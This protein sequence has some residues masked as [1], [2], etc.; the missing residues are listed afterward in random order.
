M[1]PLESDKV[2]LERKYRIFKQM[3]CAC[4][5]VRSF[6]ISAAGKAK[7]LRRFFML[8]VSLLA[9]AKWYPILFDTPMNAVRSVF[10]WLTLA[11]VLAFVVCAFALKDEKRAKF[12]KC[13]LIFAICYAGALGATF[14]TFTFLEDGIVAVLFAP[15]LVLIATIAGSALAL[16]LKRNRL[17]Y[18]LAGGATG[19]AFLAVLVCMAVYYASG[20]AEDFNGATVTVGENVALYL[21]SIGLI[22]VL[23]FLAFFFGRREKKGFDSKTISYAAIC[24]A[25]SFALSY[26]RIVK[27]PQGGSVT[28][29]SLLPLMIYAYMFGVKKGVFAGFIYG[30]LQALQ[31]PYIIHPAQF[32]LD[33]PIAFSCVGL[34]GIFAHLKSLEKLPQIQFALGALTGSGFRLF[35][36]LVSGVFAFSEYSTLDN[37]W[38]YSLVYNS[39]FVFPDI[40]IVIAA[41]VLVFSSKSFVKQ[42]RKFQ[43]HE[44]TQTKSKEA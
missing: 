21:I 14:L 37:V 15:I 42:A 30:V 2:I 8:P 12:F 44:E 40:A 6:F 17:V 31:D 4:A 41:G 33:Y 43:P 32:L 24:I 10:I 11:S 34:A 25:M 18:A 5:F 7:I 13:S 19:A 29:A 28:A 36:H 23:L 1:I 38:L 20:N 27:M 16:A 3:N 22:A 9:A 39:S 26:L 35:C